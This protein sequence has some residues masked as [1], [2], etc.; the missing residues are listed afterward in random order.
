MWVKGAGTESATQ[1]RVGL[2]TTIFALNIAAGV[3]APK[4]ARWTYLYHLGSAVSETVP[5]SWG[6]L[7]QDD[8]HRELFVVDTAVG[9]IRVFAD[10]GVQTY[11]FGD[12]STLR[13]A[14][15]AAPLSDGDVVV[16]SYRQGKPKIVRCNFRGQKRSTIDLRGVPAAIAKGFRPDRLVARKQTLYLVDRGL[17]RVVVTDGWGKYQRSHDIAALLKLSERKREETGITGF[18]VDFRDNVLFTIQ[19]LFSAFVLSP[20]GKLR[21]FGEPGGR[22]GRFNIIG[23]IAADRD[24]NLY[25]TDMLRGVVLVF[26]ST[27]RFRGEFGGAAAGFVSPRAVEAGDGRVFVSLGG[28]RGIATFRVSVPQVRKANKPRVTRNHSAQADKLG[29]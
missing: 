23:G 4:A 11:R 16:L 7:A 1:A 13:G 21:R 20:A 29:I 12:D 25:V 8:D 22:A 10:R 28:R 2:L 3:P 14:L 26:D 18:N 27:L 15:S 5:I 19:P 24:D 9:T 17:M 6:V